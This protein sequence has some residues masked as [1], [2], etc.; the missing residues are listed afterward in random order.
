MKPAAPIECLYTCSVC[1]QVGFTLRG[2]R[3]H[4]C[5]SKPGRARLTNAEIGRSLSPSSR[6]ASEPATATTD[7][8]NHSATRDARRSDTALTGTDPATVNGPRAGANPEPLS[9]PGGKLS[10]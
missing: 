9:R 10:S 8:R 7:R 3:A 6:P 5:R 1:G 4:C 2:L